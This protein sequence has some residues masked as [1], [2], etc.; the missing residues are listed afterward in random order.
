M[1]DSVIF[2]AISRGSTLTKMV[3]DQIE[4]MISEGDLSPG[5][6]LPSERDLA[7]QFNV[8]RTVIREAVA[9]LHAKSLIT[10]MANGGALIRTPSVESVSQSLAMYFNAGPVELDYGKVHEVRR[11]LEIKIAALAASRRTTADIAAL[12]SIIQNTASSSLDRHSFAETDIQF[13]TSLARSTHNELFGLLMD[14][15][16]G[17]MFRVRET[18]FDIVL[19]AYL[20]ASYR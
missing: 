20:P 2:T 9:A 12:E 7:V 15:M 14:S 4:S 18:G 13:H 6:R 11:L 1:P 16:S 17:V 5:D 3:V 19:N 10:P 8:S